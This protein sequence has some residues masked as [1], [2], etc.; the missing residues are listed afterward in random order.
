MTAYF[1]GDRRD[2][3]A[4]FL[5]EDDEGRVVGFAEATLRSHAE[6]CVT[7]P[8]AYLE[9]WYVLAT[10]R[11]CGVGTALLCAVEEWARREGCSELA[12]DAELPNVTGAA[13]HRA[14]G[15]AEVERIVCFRKSIA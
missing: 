11:G 15:F 13:A 7:S 3:A 12:S 1:D 9:G 10:H 5:A 4:V 2:P 6:G 14:L 8:V